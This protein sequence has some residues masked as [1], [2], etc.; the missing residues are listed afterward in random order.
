MKVIQSRENQLFSEYMSFFSVLNQKQ[1]ALTS[2]MNLYPRTSEFYGT[3][4]KEF[5]NLQ[6]TDPE[7]VGRRIIADH[8]DS[9]IA[10]FLRI[11]E[12]P[13][14]PVGLSLEEELRHVLDNY[15]KISDFEDSDMIYSPPLLS[16]VQRYFGIIQQAF[17][18][19]EIEEELMSGV[20]R[21]MS[22]AAVNDQ[23][24][25]FVLNELT[26]MFEQSEY[27]SLFAYFTETYLMDASC[28]DEERNQELAEILAS[29]KKT[30]VGIKVPEII[31]PQT[32]GPMI[33]S[34]LPAKYVLVVFWA[35]W[36]PH[37]A[38]LIP[39][40]K[41]LYKAYHPKGLEI[42]AISLDKDRK[43]YDQALRDGQYPWINYSEL[44]GWDCSIAHDYGIRATP[45]FV[46]LDST[47][48]V[49]GKPTRPAALKAMLEKVL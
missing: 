30:A 26:S 40:L 35:S 44:K 20:D 18:P 14:V 4:E 28:V 31:I 23:V 49:I 39:Q 38:E 19:A 41:P 32:T 36:C 17:P 47:Q 48:T 7:A 3:L 12:N 42:V 29:I 34:E 10:R 33:L 21:V 24:Y 13:K 2:L 45:V 1:Q 37:C 15:F 43:E 11:E 27:E 8:P 46:L 25:E 16:K 22:F 5:I 6:Q 9:Y